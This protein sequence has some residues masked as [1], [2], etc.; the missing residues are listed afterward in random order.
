MIRH[1]WCRVTRDYLWRVID[2][3]Q[4]YWKVKCTKCGH[5]KELG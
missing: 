3:Q 4:S 2:P 1:L 5:K